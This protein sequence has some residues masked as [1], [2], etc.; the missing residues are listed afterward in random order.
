MGFSAAVK[1]CAENRHL[2]RCKNCKARPDYQHTCEHCPNWYCITCVDPSKHQCTSLPQ[3]ETTTTSKASALARSSQWDG[4]ERK[5]PP[6]HKPPPQHSITRTMH[7][8]HQATSPMGGS[9]AGLTHECK[10]C[11]K[12]VSPLQAKPRKHLCHSYMARAPSPPLHR[13]LSTGSETTPNPHVASQ[14]AQGTTTRS[15]TGLHKAP[16]AE[17]KASRSSA[18]SAGEASKPPSHRKDTATVSKKPR[19]KAHHRDWSPTD[20]E[21]YQPLGA[22]GTSSKDHTAPEAHSAAKADKAAQDLLGTD[23]E[24]SE[25]ELTTTYRIKKKVAMA[26]SSTIEA[27][28][29]LDHHRATRGLS[30]I[31]PSTALK[32]LSNIQTAS[33]TNPQ[34]YL[35][36]CIEEVIATHGSTQSSVPQQPRYAKHAYW[37]SQLITKQLDTW[38]CRPSTRPEGLRTYRQGMFRIEDVMEFWGTYEGLT[39]TEVI[40]AIKT[41]NKDKGVSRFTLSTEAHHTMLT[42]GKTT[43][44]GQAE[45]KAHTPK[46][47]SKAFKA[48]KRY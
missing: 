22:R 18:A 28:H 17:H 37:T 13:A 12:M 30:Q 44:I 20:S 21:E 6:M 43:P 4:K 26:V 35:D 8:L 24:S 1:R 10:I 3:P 7:V 25:L 31:S 5:A 16:V 27:G 33:Y 14:A 47:K 38:A 2:S 41:H 11:R 9:K 45:H 15:T 23:D 42:V 46:A 40:Q 19:I 32:I 34:Q 29:A 48:K 39:T 36:R